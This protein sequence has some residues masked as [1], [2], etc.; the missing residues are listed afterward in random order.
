MPPIASF[1]L[2]GCIRGQH[3]ELFLLSRRGRGLLTV[4]ARLLLPW[5]GFSRGAASALFPEGKIMLRPA[6]RAGAAA[7]QLQGRG[8]ADAL[9]GP[10]APRLPLCGPRRVP[11]RRARLLNRRPHPSAHPPPSE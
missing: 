10:R 7:A 5:A 2:Q 4:R 8:G 11:Q 3:R 9:L 6:A 1:R